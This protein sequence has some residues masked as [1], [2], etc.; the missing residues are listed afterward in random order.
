VV[1]CCCERGDEPLGLYSLAVEL[2]SS[3]EVFYSLELVIYDTSGS[4]D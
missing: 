2:L 1:A 3:Q 4:E